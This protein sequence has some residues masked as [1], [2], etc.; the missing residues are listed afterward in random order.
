MAQRLGLSRS[1][2]VVMLLLAIVL[3]VLAALQ[4]QPQ[5][6]QPYDPD[7]TSSLGL[8][9][10]V[11]WLEELGHPVRSGSLRSRLD[12]QTGLL[13]LHTSSRESPAYRSDLEADAD[14]TRVYEWV[15][16]GGTLVLV[17]PDVSY[18]ALSEH[19]GVE[20]VE[21]FG[22][23][24][25]NTGQA[26]PLLPDTPANWNNSFASYSLRFFEE[27]AIVPVLARSNGELVVALQFIGEGVVWHL[28]EDFALT[29]LN[30][31]D[32]RVASL[33]PAILRTVPEGAPALFSTLHLMSPDIQND[34]VGEVATLQD[35]LYT[36]PFGQATLL[37]IVSLFVYL[38]LQ[39][40]R[41]GPPLPATTANRPREAAEY[42]TALASLQRRIRQP[43]LVADHHRQR[44]KSALGRLAQLPTDLPDAEWLAQ[45][46]RA[47]VLSAEQYNEVSELLAG[48]AKQQGKASNEAE[49]IQLVRATDTLLASLPQANKLLVR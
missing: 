48:Y 30:L 29:N 12:A 2:L 5:R 13:F 19:F 20:Q 28:T 49:L 18:F 1:Q 10:L 3:V 31:R 32:E 37:L 4:N 45:L 34:E 44:L 15:Q 35:W 7:D 41:L 17:G 36:T 6:V 9:A 38:L 25:L 39:G 24:L 46:R 8:R 22:D 33:L 43:S 11:L 40:R 21:S 16:Q 42:V 27:R 47:E 23:I 14:A 26:Q